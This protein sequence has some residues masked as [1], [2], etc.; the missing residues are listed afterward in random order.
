M[1]SIFLLFPG[2]GS[3][4]DVTQYVRDKTVLFQSQLMNTERKSVID[5]LSFSVKH[6]TALTAKFDAASSKIYAYAQDEESNYI[7]TGYIAP[8]FSQNIRVVAED[9][10]LEILDNS[11]LLDE[12]IPE[13]IYLPAD[14]DDPAWPILSTSSPLTSIVGY[15]LDSAGYNTATIFDAGCPNIATTVEQISEQ[16]GDRTYREFL[17]QLLFEYGY[18]L[19]FTGTGQFTVY[20]WNKASVSASVTLSDTATDRDNAFGTASGLQR[21][22]I[23]SEYDGVKLEYSETD[24]IENVLLYRENLPISTTPGSSGF[25]GQA[26]AA[27][28]YF[29]SDGDID[30]IYQEY[31]ADWLDRPY[32]LRETRKKNKDISL[33]ATSDQVTDF[34]GDTDIDIDSEIY[35]QTRAKVLFQ[36]TG[37]EIENIYYFDIYGTAKFRSAIKTIT[38]TGDPKKPQEFQAEFI[39]DDTAAENLL[40][41]LEQNLNFNEWEYSFQLV[42][43]IEPGTI[44][45]IVQ[46]DPAIST[47]AVIL[48]MAKTDGMPMY[49]YT[50]VGLS[51]FSSPVFD[52]ETLRSRIKAT[53]DMYVQVKAQEN[54]ESY[55][56]SVATTTQTNAVAEALQDIADSYGYDTYAEFLT[57]LG[58]NTIFDPGTGYLN[59]D[60]IDVDTLISSGAIVITSDLGDLAVLDTVGFDDLGPTIAGSGYILTSRIDVENLYVKHLDAADGDLGAINTEELFSGTQNYSASTAITTVTTWLSGLGISAFQWFF[61]EGTYNSVDIW[62]M[63]YTTTSIL[64]FKFTDGGSITQDSSN[65]DYALNISTVWDVVKVRSD[66]NVSGD[67]YCN[68]ITTEGNID[69]GGHL[70]V[71]DTVYFKGTNGTIQYNTTLDAFSFDDACIDCGPIK[72]NNTP[73]SGYA[74]IYSDD[75]FTLIDAVLGSRGTGWYRASG[76]GIGEG[77]SAM[78]YHNGSSY[79]STG[80]DETISIKYI[81]KVSATVYHVYV[82]L[83]SAT[84]KMGRLIAD[85]TDGSTLVLR[86]YMLS[87]G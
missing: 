19:D 73:Y 35:E 10:A 26:I 65:L 85:S 13:D 11:Y 24:I 1:T 18:V 16:K 69:V 50:A 76:G 12:T 51:P 63:R 37:A 3:Y 25:T 66:L 47:T 52:S 84:S 28:D 9:I 38:T 64:Q 60:V 83:I 58:S 72:M 86:Q 54:A 59:I 15:I 79:V 75:L 39:F 20:Q 22:K 8:T 33:I 81:N 44:V 2:D 7:I 5:Q 57:A 31:R 71:D 82:T 36:N 42:S 6:D 4:T 67:V 40:G 53:D 27:S 43:E 78:Q 68:D 87:I 34:S 32:L 45:N 46:T 74:Q 77:G 56:D 21:T 80:S 29:P 62:A 30:D 23:D 49:S 14:M 55:T 41:G 61:V 48:T 70:T 17:D